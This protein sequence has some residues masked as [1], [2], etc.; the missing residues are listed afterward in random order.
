MVGMVRVDEGGRLQAVHVFEQFTV[1]ERVIDVELVDR[2]V[3][4]CR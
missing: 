4:Q 2:L 1:Q 3:A